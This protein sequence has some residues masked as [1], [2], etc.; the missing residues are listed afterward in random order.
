MLYAITY[1]FP[2]VIGAA[3]VPTIFW[4]CYFV[5]NH[6]WIEDILCCKKGPYYPY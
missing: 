3:A 4:A 6:A 5:L 1:P 2:N